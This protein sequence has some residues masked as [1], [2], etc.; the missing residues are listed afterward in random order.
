ML[1]GLV[2]KVA[3]LVVG[4]LVHLLKTSLR[5]ENPLIVKLRSRIL[6]SDEE[7]A[8]RAEDSKLSVELDLLEAENFVDN[9]YYWFWDNKNED[10]IPAEFA[11]SFVNLKNY[12]QLHAFMYQAGTIWGAMETADDED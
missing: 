7:I 6:P 3:F 4:S 11:E 8:L 10:I 5:S 1:L 9:M 12:Q 2:Q